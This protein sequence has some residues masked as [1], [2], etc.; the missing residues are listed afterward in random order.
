[1]GY[2]RRKDHKKVKCKGPFPS[3][4][5]TSPNHRDEPTQGLQNTLPTVRNEPTTF[6]K[7]HR[8]STNS[9]TRPLKLFFTTS[10]GLFCQFGLLQ[11]QVSTLL[12]FMLERQLNIKPIAVTTK[13]DDHAS[14]EEA[15]QQ[16]NMRETVTFNHTKGLH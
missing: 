12:L 11:V 6:R 13:S 7:Q 1:M 10:C 14:M 9:T 2:V 8:C 15:Q 4:H 5:M 3:S 16:C